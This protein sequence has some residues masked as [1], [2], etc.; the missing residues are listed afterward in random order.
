MDGPRGKI[1][2]LVSVLEILDDD[3][4][5]SSPENLLPLIMSIASYRKPKVPRVPHYENV[6]TTYDA[7]DFRR[8]FR[9][10]PRTFMRGSL[11]S[12]FSQHISNQQASSKTKCKVSLLKKARALTPWHTKLLFLVHL[13]ITMHDWSRA[14]TNQRLLNQENQEIFLRCGFQGFRGFLNPRNPCRNPQS[15]NARLTE[16]STKSTK[17]RLIERT[18]WAQSSHARSYLRTL[19]ASMNSA[20]RSTPIMTLHRN[21]IAE[22]QVHSYAFTRSI[23]HIIIATV[24]EQIKHSQN[25]LFSLNLHHKQSVLNYW[26][27]TTYMSI[28]G[29]ST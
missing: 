23:L 7:E 14:Y 16:K 27:V 9:V 1:A 12:S 21:S 26:S 6:T 18:Q 3:P 2:L 10:L 15:S 28:S 24:K 29:V 13:I 19:K 25:G 11:H 22:Q 17:S 20:Q 8:H 4:D 5:P